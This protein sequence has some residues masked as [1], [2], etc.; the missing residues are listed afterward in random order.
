MVYGGG[1]LPVYEDDEAIGALEIRREGL[2]TRFT[3]LLPPGH[4]PGLSRLW[5]LGQ[6][7]G[8][9]PLALLEPVPGGRRLSLR[10]TRLELGRLPAAP[11]RAE[12]RDAGG[13]CSAFS[14][15]SSEETDGHTSDIGHWF[16]MTPGG[17]LVAPP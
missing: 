13:E 17:D 16:A 9:A 3:A 1:A 10:L 4:G 7:G 6:D 5:I 14:F 15:Q 11:V 12:A 8:A 2:Y